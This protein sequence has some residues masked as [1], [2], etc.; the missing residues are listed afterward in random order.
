MIKIVTWYSALEVLNVENW[1][2]SAELL[3]SYNMGFKQAAILGPVSF[4]LGMSR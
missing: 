3:T 4:F 1:T 2:L